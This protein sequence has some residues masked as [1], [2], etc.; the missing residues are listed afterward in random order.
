MLKNGCLP[1]V[2]VRCY[3]ELAFVIIKVALNILE[4]NLFVT[5][6]T[7]CATYSASIVYYEYVQ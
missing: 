2:T 1:F 6:T 5:G 4:I 3:R 7:L